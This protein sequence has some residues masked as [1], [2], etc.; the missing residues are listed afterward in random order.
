LFCWDT[1]GD[2][3][4]FIFSR[5]YISSIERAYSIPLGKEVKEISKDEF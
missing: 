3:P 2:H 5:E 1:E 4:K